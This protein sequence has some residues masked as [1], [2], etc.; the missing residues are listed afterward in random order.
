VTLRR[1][2]D[3][4]A[5]PNVI[6]AKLRRWDGRKF[7]TTGD[8]EAAYAKLNAAWTDWCSKTGCDVLPLAPLVDWI[9][10]N[11]PWDGTGY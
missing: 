11:C 1:R 4:T 5:N 7:S 9:D 3:P 6:P 8:W 2:C 10:N